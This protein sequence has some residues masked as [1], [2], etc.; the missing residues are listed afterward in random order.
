A[1]SLRSF[2]NLDLA[3]RLDATARF[4]NEFA[5]WIKESRDRLAHALADAIGSAQAVAVRSR[6]RLDPSGAD[7][8]VLAAADIG[9]WLLTA[10]VE[11][12]GAGEALRDAPG[13]WEEAFYQ[14][15]PLD[16]PPPDT[17]TL[18]VTI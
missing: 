5:V 7:R 10:V 13:R 11:A 6:G 16:V 14:P 4:G 1:G 15:P 18:R 9:A 17:G 8:S 3:A 2:S 12:R